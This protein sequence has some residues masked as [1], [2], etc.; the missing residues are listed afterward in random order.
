MFTSRRD[1]TKRRMMSYAADTLQRFALCL[2]LCDLNFVLLV[3][4]FYFCFLFFFWVFLLVILLRVRFATPFVSVGPIDLLLALLFAI[5][6]ESWLQSCLS[7]LS[8]RAVRSLETRLR[9]QVQRVNS[10]SRTWHTLH[11]FLGKI[12]AVI[13]TPAQTFLDV[14]KVSLRLLYESS[15]WGGYTWLSGLILPNT[16]TRYT[17]C[18]RCLRGGFLV[19]FLVEEKHSLTGF[20]FYW[21]HAWVW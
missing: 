5:R 18:T 3:S 7:G 4:V 20:L 10:T 15:F 19:Y 1:Q 14:L 11:N 17:R 13:I 16:H 2:R 21:W 8:G 12:H 6:M 9:I